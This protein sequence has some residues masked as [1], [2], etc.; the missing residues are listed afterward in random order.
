MLNGNPSGVVSIIQQAIENDLG[1]T[2]ALNILTGTP[3]IT[4][5]PDGSTLETVIDLGGTQTFTTSFNTGLSGLGLS[6]QTTGGVTITVQYQLDLDFVFSKTEGFQFRLPTP[7]DSPSFTFN[8]TAS[9]T[10]GA[11]LQAKLFFLNVMA[12]NPSVNPVTDP[13]GG[14][15]LNASL[16]ISLPDESGGTGLET[17]SQFVSSIVGLTATISGSANVNLAPGCRP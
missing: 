7:A 4:L 13:T 2:S 5:S 11:N 16:A 15:D 6:F 10:P 8:V 17:V 14:T 3:Q 1:P 12:T 9:L